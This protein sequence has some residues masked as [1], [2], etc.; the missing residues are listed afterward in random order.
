MTKLLHD[1]RAILGF[2]GGT[3]ARVPKATRI[4][5]ILFTKF[6]PVL[7]NL[8][9][10]GFAN[11]FQGGGTRMKKGGTGPDTEVFCDFVT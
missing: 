5:V 7:K 1:V 6:F 4:H 9:C 10:L 3:R 8:S 11:F 2:E